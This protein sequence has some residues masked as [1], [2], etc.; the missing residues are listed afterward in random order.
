MMAEGLLSIA[1]GMV[2]LVVSF[3]VYAWGIRRIGGGQFDAR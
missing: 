3:K 2:A 1:L